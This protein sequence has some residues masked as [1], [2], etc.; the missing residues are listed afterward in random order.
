[1]IIRLPMQTLQLAIY[2]ICGRTLNF[3]VPPKVVLMRL[4]RIT[5]ILVIIIQ[6]TI[7]LL[8]IILMLIQEHTLSLTVSD[9]YLYDTI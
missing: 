2:S 5:G 6:V 9:G 3:V 7:L 8:Y 4:Q 1:M